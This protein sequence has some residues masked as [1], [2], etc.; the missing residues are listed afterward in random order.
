MSTVALNPSPSSHLKNMWNVL[1][2]QPDYPLQAWC[3]WCIRSATIRDHHRYSFPYDRIDMKPRDKR[4]IL[5]SLD[6]LCGLSSKRKIS[7]L[8]NRYSGRPLKSLMLFHMVLQLGMW[9][10]CLKHSIPLYMLWEMLKYWQGYSKLWSPS[11]GS[12]SQTSDCCQ[13]P[14]GWTWFS[15]PSR[16]TWAAVYVDSDCCMWLDVIVGIR[17]HWTDLLPSYGVDK[18]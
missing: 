12:V 11:G 10:Y 16:E 17:L 4:C 7:T 18:M 6:Y 2:L 9:Y 15:E 3:I 5:S 8:I 1:S 14:S 13:N